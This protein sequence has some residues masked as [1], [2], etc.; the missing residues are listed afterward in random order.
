MTEISLFLHFCEYSFIFFYYF[1]I[2]ISFFFLRTYL[3][4]QL[5]YA[6]SLLGTMVAPWGTAV[7]EWA[8]RTCPSIPAREQSNQGTGTALA[9]S[10]VHLPGD[11]DGQRPGHQST[12]GDL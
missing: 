3:A 12:A 1:R 10:S 9:L 7:Q 2:S 11:G 4:E 8:A 6:Y 5:L